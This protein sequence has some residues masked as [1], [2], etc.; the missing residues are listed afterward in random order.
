MIIRCF[1]CFGKPAELILPVD[2]KVYDLCPE[3]YRNQDL[4]VSLIRQIEERAQLRKTIA[5]NSCWGGLN[6]AISGM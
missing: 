3:C 1:A 6:R 5:D 4:S 2:G